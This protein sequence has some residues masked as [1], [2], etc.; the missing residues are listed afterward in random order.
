M[1]FFS[2]SLGKKR[3]R[4]LTPWPL[5]ATKNTRSKCDNKMMLNYKKITLADT[6]SVDFEIFSHFWSMFF[7]GQGPDFLTLRRDAIWRI[8]IMTT[9]IA[10]TL[11]NWNDF[12]DSS[13]F[14]DWVT[15]AYCLE[16]DF[17]KFLISRAGFFVCPLLLGSKGLLQEDS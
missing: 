3:F 9:S 7:E 1:L 2:L 6:K 15:A 17:E 8:F 13:E 5:I 10:V 16:L 11:F 12:C 14:F 4:F